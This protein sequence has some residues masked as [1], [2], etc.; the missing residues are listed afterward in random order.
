VRIRVLHPPRSST[1]SSRALFVFPLCVRSLFPNVSRSDPP[2]T[3]NFPFL[4]LRSPSRGFVAHSNR[5]PPVSQTSFISMFLRSNPFFPRRPARHSSLP[6]I[7]TILSAAIFLLPLVLAFFLMSP[8]SRETT[9][10]L[11]GAE[12][13]D[14]LTTMHMSCIFAP[15]PAARPPVPFFFESSTRHVPPFRDRNMVWTESNS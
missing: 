5:T 15:F 7:S 14:F 3:T 10:L 6:Q 8:P 4:P 13:D 9:L 2:P 1:S 11:K 12:L